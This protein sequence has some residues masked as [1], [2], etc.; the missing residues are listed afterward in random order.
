MGVIDL[1]VSRMYPFNMQVM[2]EPKKIFLMILVTNLCTLNVIMW[3]H[4]LP[5]EFLRQGIDQEQE[6]GDAH[7]KGCTHHEVSHFPHEF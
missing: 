7:K 2:I 3:G 4:Y 6:D 5:F 1:R